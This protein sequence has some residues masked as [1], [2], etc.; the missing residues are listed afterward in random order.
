MFGLGQSPMSFI[1]VSTSSTMR[2]ITSLIV[3]DKTRVYNQ[4]VA[5]KELPLVRCTFPH[6]NS[7]TKSMLYCHKNP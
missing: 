6:Y 2:G 1:M 5:D 4:D 7:L 3:E